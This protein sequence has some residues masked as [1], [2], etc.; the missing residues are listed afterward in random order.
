MQP[1]SACG[2]ASSTLDYAQVVPSAV[3]GRGVQQPS[4]D[5]QEACDVNVPPERESLR[6]SAR[7]SCERG[8]GPASLGK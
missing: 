1:H 3:E 6:S 5:G 8:W 4:E 2:H 7:S